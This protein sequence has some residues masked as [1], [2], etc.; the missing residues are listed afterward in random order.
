[1]HIFRRILVPTDFS[2]SANRAFSFALL[3]ARAG[4]ATIHLMHDVEIPA[5]TMTAATIIKEQLA[6]AKAESRRKMETL[7]ASHDASDVV[8][9][10]VIEQS[11]NPV[12]SIPYYAEVHDIDLIVMGA[13]GHHSL[14]EKLIGS[15]AER[16]LREA[17]CPVVT[18]SPDDPWTP[19]EHIAHILVPVDFSP[20]SAEALRL[21]K[22]LA[23]AFGARLSLLH[24]AAWD[25]EEDVRR[26]LHDLYAREAGANG[27]VELLVS[28]DVPADAIV[29]L[30]GETGA[31]LIVMTSHSRK[32]LQRVLEGNT[33]DAVVPRAPCPVMT[34]PV[35]A[36][37]VEEQA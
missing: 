10:Q 32:G 19:P 14:K 28:E 2:T 30:A 7:I 24:A 18:V 33:A 27:A 6:Q 9:E 21:A 22:A 3:L 1:M 4:P 15:R 26:Q 29:E 34:I 35:K 37:T 36:V 5:E 25:S 20:H 13:H 8:S 17:P 12:R 31:D 11:T 23:T 16:V